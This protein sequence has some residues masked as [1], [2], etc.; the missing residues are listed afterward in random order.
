ML[1]QI[2]SPLD[3]IANFW[4]TI[5]SNLPYNEKINGHLLKLIY[6]RTAYSCYAMQYFNIVSLTAG[7]EDRTSDFIF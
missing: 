5:K 2:L 4:H 1:K 7:P 3:N 6:A